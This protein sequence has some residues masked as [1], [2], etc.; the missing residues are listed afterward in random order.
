MYP[1]E[2]AEVCY[3]LGWVAGLGG[4]CSVLCVTFSDVFIAR[5]S[6]CMAVTT[7]L[8]CPSNGQASS[9]RPWCMVLFLVGPLLFTRMVGWV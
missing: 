9:T 2:T 7:F 8:R 1:V 3:E 4:T 5:G 6:I